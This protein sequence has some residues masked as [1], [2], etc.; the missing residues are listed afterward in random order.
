MT[1]K[2]AINLEKGQLVNVKISN[3]TGA[4]IEVAE[5]M[6]MLGKEYINVSIILSNKNILKLKHKEISF[7]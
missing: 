3:V 6:T 5:E 4:V 2:Q 7:I 1:Y